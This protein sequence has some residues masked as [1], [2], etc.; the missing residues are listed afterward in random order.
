M[1]L[2]LKFCEPLYNSQ[3]QISMLHLYKKHTYV[4]GAP[5]IDCYT[6]TGKTILT[7]VT[8]S[9]KL[10]IKYTRPFTGT[11]DRINT[12]PH[13]LREMLTGGCGD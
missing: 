11:A 12:F 3:R 10:T 8:Y 6:Y 13:A 4:L 5:N 1:L 2:I 9:T 7:I